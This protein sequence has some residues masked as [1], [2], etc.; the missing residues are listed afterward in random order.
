MVFHN[1]GEFDYP[2]DFWS[3]LDDHVTKSR[4]FAT[5]EENMINEITGKTDKKHRSRQ[6][7]EQKNKRNILVVMI[8]Y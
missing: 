5:E 3:F 1:S 8:V 6:I 4:D 2:D 7:N